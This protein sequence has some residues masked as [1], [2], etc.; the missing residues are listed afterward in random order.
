VHQVEYVRHAWRVRS[1]RTTRWCVE[2]IHAEQ[3]KWAYYMDK[4]RLQMVV[5]HVEH[6]MKGTHIVAAMLGWA[7]PKLTYCM[8]ENRMQMG[9]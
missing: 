3:P 8:D 1:D 6:F 7:R 9:V 5:Q 4:K 2:L